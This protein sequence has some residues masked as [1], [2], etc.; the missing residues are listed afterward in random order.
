MD[1]NK[2]MLDSYL[3]CISWADCTGDNDPAFDNSFGFSDE[4][5][6]RAKNDVKAFLEIMG[7]EL[8]NE[9]LVTMAGHDL[10]LTRNGHGT[11]FW[12]RPEKYG[13]ELSEKCDNLCGWRKLF[14]ELDIYVGDD[15]LI[16]FGG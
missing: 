12:D 2:I 15:N 3:E 6:L 8:T 16:Y 11:G 1:K 5:L 4:L 7:D 13:R 10:W 9:D 14:S